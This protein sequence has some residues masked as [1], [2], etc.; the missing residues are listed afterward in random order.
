MT[1]SP[2]LEH[3]TTPPCWVVQV[4]IA[5]PSLALL[6]LATSHLVVQ[7][8]LWLALPVVSKARPSLVV[9]SDTI[10]LTTSGVTNVRIVAGA[11]NDIVNFNKQVSGVSIVGGAGNDS[12]T[13]NSA[14][15]STGVM[16][17]SNTYFFGHGT[18]ND[19]MTFAAN[20]NPIT[21]TIAIDQAYGTT[22][23]AI[24]WTQT[25]S[26]VTIGG[27][28]ANQGSIFV[29]GNTKPTLGTLGFTFTTVA[30]SVI[31]DLG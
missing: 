12:I 2:S 30:A 6:L 31:T 13:F 23:N 5:L 9:L 26:L 21:F 25:T 7:E 27:D 18:G 11:G 14:T 17:S 28:G 22:A 15:S 29:T 10:N 1:P 3:S 16:G 24:T 8:L 20:T 4:L 19:T